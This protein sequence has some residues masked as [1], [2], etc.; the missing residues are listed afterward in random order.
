MNLASYRLVLKFVSESKTRILFYLNQGPEK[1]MRVSHAASSS[2]VE[3]CLQASVTTDMN[4]HHVYLKF[5]EYQPLPT[6]RFP[7]I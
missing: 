4:D 7:Y 5:R 2:S 1:V 6:I 3:Q